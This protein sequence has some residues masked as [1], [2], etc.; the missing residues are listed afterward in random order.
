M[1]SRYDRGMNSRSKALLLAMCGVLLATA[2]AWLRHDLG[3]AA[4]GF[5][6][7]TI[8]AVVAYRTRNR[9]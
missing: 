4:I 2:N 5:V 9:A 6:V 8:I 1:S 3:L 7:A